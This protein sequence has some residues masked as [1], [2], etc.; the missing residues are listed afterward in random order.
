MIGYLGRMR[1]YFAEMFPLLPHL[2]AAVL[3]YLA[4]AVFARRVHGANSSLWSAWFLL[5]TWSYLAVPLMLRLM[6]EIK[7][8]DIDRQLFANRP[9]PSGRVR[10]SDIRFSLALV[11]AVYVASNLVS[12]PTLIA[13]A[14]ITLYALLMFRR[15]FLEQAHRASLPLTL[16]THNPIVPLSISYGYFLF[17]AEQGTPLLDLRW[18]VLVTFVVNLWMPLLAWELSRKIRAPQ[19]EDAYVTYTQLLGS[20]G[21][22]AAVLAVQLV[23]LCA[24][25][26][27]CV[28]DVLPWQFLILPAAGW[29][30]TA[31]AGG[32]FLRAPSTRTAWL[33]PYTEGFAVANLVSVLIVSWDL[34]V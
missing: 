34:L 26:A 27:L 14:V 8:L 28:T 10:E 20:R 22:V 3:T 11:V 25:G 2:L 17:A 16:A 9:V 15:F 5:G 6:D 32:R 33:R 24:G 1:L 21:A 31:W 4:A 30:A 29:L 23:G 7:D 12:V 19:D 18:P 13:A